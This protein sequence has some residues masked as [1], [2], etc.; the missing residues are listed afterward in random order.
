[1]LIRLAQREDYTQLSGLLN[2]SN[3]T[4]PEE[5]KVEYQ[6][7]QEIIGS[8]YLDLIVAENNSLLVGSCYLNIMPNMTRGGRP[9]AVIENV[10]THSA[11]C[12]QGIGQALITRALEL[13]WKENC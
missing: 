4:D 6:I 8:N 9:Y 13:V 2:H 10:I 3:P 12:N 7:F 11:S 1:M 5:T